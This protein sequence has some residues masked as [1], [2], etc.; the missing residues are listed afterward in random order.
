VH[1]L[2]VHTVGSVVVVGAGFAGLAAARVLADAGRD[3]TVLE[4]RER[5]GGRVWS[6]CLDN[7]EIAELGGEWIMPGDTEVRAWAERFGVPLAVA[8]IDYRR[9]EGRGTRASTPED[10]DAFLAAANDAFAVV[11]PHEA[12]G[13]SLGTFLDALDAPDAGRDAVRMRIQGTIA[14][15]P[16][17]VALRSMAGHGS[18]AAPS[19]VY[20]RMSTGNQTLAEAIAASL[21]DVRLGHRVR[22]VAHDADGV[23]AGVEGDVTVVGAATIVALPVRV[24]AQLRFEPFLPD[25]L[26]IALRELPMGVAAKLAIPVDGAPTVRAVQSDELPFWCWV[27]NGADGTVRRC[28]TAF[29]GSE[30]AQEALG[31]GTGDPGPWLERLMSI[32]PDLVA[33]GAPVLKAWALDPLARGAYS[34]WDNRSWDRMEEFDRTVGRLAFAGEHTAGPEHHGTMEGALRSG[35][36]AATQMLEL[37]G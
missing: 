10:H 17:H 6:V 20:Y 18:F 15:D 29:A 12:A 27:A 32:N 9:R 19:A 8:G 21:P 31:T 11:P 23:T 2:P 33:S 36:R 37:L 35:V 7:G 14:T 26:A 30:R 28:L 1:P 5:V 13:L 4:A 22:S 24:T 3:V 16:G 25:D 34:A